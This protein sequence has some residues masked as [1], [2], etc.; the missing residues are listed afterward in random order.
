MSSIPR[1]KFLGRKILA[2][3]A[4]AFAAAIGTLPATA[5][6]P[7]VKVG[8]VLPLSGPNAQ[9]GQNS[10]N[11]I[12]MA[13]E[14]IN[15]AGGIKGLNGAKLELVYADVPAPGGAAA[16]TQRLVSQDKVVAVVGAFAS[17]ITL[18]VSEVTERAGVP[19]IT[20]SFADQITERGYRHVFQVSPKASTFGQEQ[21]LQAY[22]IAAAAGVKVRNIAIMYE[23]TAYGTGQ[24]KGLREAAKLAG[25][26]VSMDEAY[27]LGITDVT[28]MINR[29]RTSDAQ[30]VF[31]I[32]YLNDSLLIIRTM[33]QQRINTPAV[34]GAAGYVIP[35]FKA[36]LGE[37]AEGVFSVAP[38]NYDAIPDIAAAY[39]GRHG[40]FMA[41]EAIMYGA[42]LEHVAEALN[43]SA[44][45]DPSKVRDAIAELKHCE[46]FA[47]GIPGGCTAFNARGLTTTAFPIFVQW[48]GNDLVTVFP[49]EV[50]KSKPIWPKD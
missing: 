31:P 45:R 36:G 50:A 3:G 6:S 34:G 33:R 46:G 35:D 11:G 29:L 15:A 26:T 47:K 4:T 37:F 28:P 14:R 8:V 2:L 43:K 49:P 1:R 23:D 18:A 19:L 12:E 20:H 9:F 10:R 41:H 24:A 39:K 7:S 5:Q 27:P 44:S 30:I 17:G 22:K 48:R 13:L 42:A 25:I 32:S 16:A 38:A 21:L 40:V